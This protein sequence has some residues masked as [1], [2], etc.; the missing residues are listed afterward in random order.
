MKTGLSSSL[1]TRV[2]RAVCNA[3][4][5]LWVRILHAPAEGLFAVVD[6]YESRNSLTDF[7]RQQE[8]QHTSHFRLIP[9]ECVLASASFPWSTYVS[10]SRNVL[11]INLE[12]CLSFVLNETFPRTSVIRNISW[13][14]N[15]YKPVKTSPAELEIWERTNRQ[16][17]Y[18]FGSCTRCKNGVLT[19]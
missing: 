10:A 9:S 15:T 5:S 12:V 2:L 8:Q 7:Y 1:S 11:Y 3:A 17:R 19:Q 16:A 14:C 18:S 6:H 13:T 4:L